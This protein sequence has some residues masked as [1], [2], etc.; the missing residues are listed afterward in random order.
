MNRL[1]RAFLSF[2]YLL[3]VV[4]AVLSVLLLGVCFA[5]ILVELLSL[6][7]FREDHCYF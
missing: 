1:L 5:N 2:C 3:F 4:T 7:L 6:L